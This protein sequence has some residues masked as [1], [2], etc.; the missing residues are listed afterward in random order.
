V[1]EVENDAVYGVK[2]ITTGKELI[3]DFLF[4]LSL[5]KTR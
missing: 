3:Y 4:P 5:E 2:L 1:N